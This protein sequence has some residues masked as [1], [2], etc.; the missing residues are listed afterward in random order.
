MVVAGD[1]SVSQLERCRAETYREEQ[2]QVPCTT[3]V[4]QNDGMCIALSIFDACLP[5]YFT[6]IG[7]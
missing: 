2:E 1:I 6:N 7:G 3:L 5:L 4:A